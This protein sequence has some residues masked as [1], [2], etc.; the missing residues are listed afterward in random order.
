M[1]T[2]HTIAQRVKDI[3]TRE[4]PQTFSLY[5]GYGLNDGTAVHFP[6]GV[7]IREN[8]NDKGRVTLAEYQY[9]DDSRLTFRYR[10]DNGYT[11]KA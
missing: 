4:C 11:L 5:A 1:T 10:E 9:A 7:M 8:R 2:P 3:I 6:T